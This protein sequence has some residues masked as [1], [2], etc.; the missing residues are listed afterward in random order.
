MIWEHSISVLW[1]EQ[2]FFS[3]K[4]L[5]WCTFNDPDLR[6]GVLLW[7]S[8]R[9]WERKHENKNHTACPARGTRT[10]GT[11]GPCFAAHP[12]QALWAAQLLKQPPW[13]HLSGSGSVSPGQ[14]PAQSRSSP[15]STLFS[16]WVAVPWFPGIQKI[17]QN[18]P[19]LL[20]QPPLCWCQ[21]NIHIVHFASS[22]HLQLT[23]PLFRLTT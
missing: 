20:P 19:F 5:Y 17:A 10:P 13:R 2:G 16:R 4:S 8:E 15:C 11:L 6:T 12:T 7:G 23:M 22:Q 1:K 3:V 14:V 18:I 21:S 9:E